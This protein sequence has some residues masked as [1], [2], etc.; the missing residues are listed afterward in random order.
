MG[1]A[2]AAQRGFTLLEILVAVGVTA[3]LAVQGVPYLRDLLQRREVQVH[4][5]AFRSAARL[6]RNLALDR[7]TVVTLCARQA[8]PLGD[9]NNCLPSGRDWSQG[10]IA[11]VDHGVRGRVDDGD[12]VLHVEVPTRAVGRMV[13]T[14]RYL[15][16]QASGVSLN[17]ASRFTFLPPGAPGGALSAPGD[18]LVCVNKPG[19]ARIVDADAC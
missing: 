10:W 1:Q 19:R 16:F 12:R 17:A 14:V 8:A 2:V 15:S 11:F 4:A 9:G 5:E 13:A 6:A 18:L 7:Q 3:V